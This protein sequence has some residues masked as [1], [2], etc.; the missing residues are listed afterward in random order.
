MNRQATVV[1]P[2]L[3]A[4]EGARALASRLRGTNAEAF[5]FSGEEMEEMGIVKHNKLTNRGF[6]GDRWGFGTTSN[7]IKKMARWNSNKYGF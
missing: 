1:L 7:N 2:G 3:I 6:N 5:F 4:R